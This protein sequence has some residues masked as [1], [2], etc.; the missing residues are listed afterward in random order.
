MFNFCAGEDDLPDIDDDS[1]D[2]VGCDAFW[3]KV[4]DNILGK[5]FPGPKLPS[6]TLRLKLSFWAPYIGPDTSKRD[7]VV[8]TEHRKIHR[9]TGEAEIDC[10]K[11]TQERLIEEMFEGNALQV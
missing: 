10:R 7:F 5:A 6:L 4:H 2:Y 8:N 3:D 11:I 9:D 1:T